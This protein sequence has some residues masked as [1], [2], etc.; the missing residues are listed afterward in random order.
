MKARR[1][2]VDKVADSATKAVTNLIDTK[3]KAVEFLSQSLKDMIENGLESLTL[4]ELNL[5]YEAEGENKNRSSV[6][7]KIEDAIEALEK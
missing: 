3:E 7:E 1:G 6:I 2:I 5:I 4:D